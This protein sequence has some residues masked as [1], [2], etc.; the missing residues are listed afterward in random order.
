[1]SALY[2]GTYFGGI[3]QTDVHR[4]SLQLI[5]QQRQLLETRMKLCLAPQVV[6]RIA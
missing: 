6:P 2:N 4:I 1:M 5:L 3:L